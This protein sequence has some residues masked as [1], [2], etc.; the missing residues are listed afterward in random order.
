MIIFIFALVF[1]LS[2]CTDYVGQI[3]DQ[4]DELHAKA[5]LNSEQLI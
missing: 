2:A 1:L 3:D 5:A 4:I